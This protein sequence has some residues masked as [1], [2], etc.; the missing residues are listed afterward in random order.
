MY[1]YICMSIDISTYI[2]MH[3]SAYVYFFY[4]Y[5]HI[6]MHV[7]IRISIHLCTHVVYLRKIGNFLNGRNC[8]RIHRLV[9]FI[10][11]NCMKRHESTCTH[12][13][14]IT[15][16][17]QVVIVVFAPSHRLL[18]H[19]CCSTWCDFCVSICVSASVCERKCMH[20]I[21]LLFV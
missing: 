9:S 4:M 17:M 6:C 1:I 16:Q 20:M 3:M 8:T 11:T 2:F 19:S 15:W 14:V 7:H 18:A 5:I 12:T 13:C 10:H 21:S